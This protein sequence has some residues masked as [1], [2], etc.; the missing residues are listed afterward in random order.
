LNDAA[1]R[2]LARALLGACGLLG[3][4]GDD[5]EVPPVTRVHMDFAAASFF[6]APFPSDHRLQ[7]NGTVE[8]S[9][10]PNPQDH[11]IARQ[12]LTLLDGRARGFSAS[13]GV[14][15]ALDGAVDPAS[16]PELDETV[17][18]GASV[19]LLGIDPASPDYGRRYP[20]TVRFE[21]D[22]GPF[23]AENMLS[24]VP[25]QGVPL[26]ASC[27]YA[28]VVTQAVRDR[29]GQ[30]LGM[31]RALEQ[32]ASGQRP[33]GLSSPA[34]ADYREALARLADLGLAPSALA[35]LAVFTTDEPEAELFLLTETARARPLPEPLSPFLLTEVFDEYCVYH[36]TLQMPVYQRGEPP[37]AEQGGD[38]AFSD[39]GAVF[40]HDEE[41]RI[42]ITVPRAAMPAA[43]WPTAVMIRTGGGGDRPLV[44]RG[45]RAEPGGP[46]IEP[47]EG[48]ALYFARAGFAGVSVDGPHG[49]LRNVTGSDEQFLVFNIGNPAALRDNL[50]QSAMEIALLPDVL[51][52]LSIDLQGCPDAETDGGVGLF[53]VS[54][55]ALMGHS[56]GATIAPLALAVEPRYRAAILS[57]AGGSWLE[58]LVHKELPV[59]VRPLAEVLLGYTAIGRELHT[60]DPFL[61]LLQ[62]AGESADPPIY[63]RRL[64]GALASEPRHV[65]MLQGIVDHYILPPIANA[66]SLSLGLDLALPALDEDHA[67]LA[68]YRPLGELLVHSSREARPLPIASNREVAGEPCTLAVVQHPGDGVEDG[69]EV[70]F[71]TELPK[72]QY[73]CFLERFLAGEPQVV[74]PGGEPC[75]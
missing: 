57:G 73:R 16:L 28:A 11:H 63:G 55:L 41:A 10:Y 34:F 46:S 53:D 45:V 62:W 60:H 47:G 8:L 15:F 5:A 26:L 68:P 75:F 37:Y 44:D 35:G 14:F 30:A 13:A 70:V 29:A 18:D 51:A 7:D 59:P 74:P 50:R 19:L 43:G 3:G 2:W 40:D 69:H 61:S 39:D 21:A 31:P 6:A 58:N 54:Q 71:Q 56:M 1:Q 42:V 66:T 67:E 36:S 65:L 25:L 52:A 20:I 49:G 72:R 38:I 17:T 12:V 48:P 22:G 27:R 24:L 33:A 4:C 32:L 23:G 9:A 64:T